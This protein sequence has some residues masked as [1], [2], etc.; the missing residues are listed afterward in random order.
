MSLKTYQFPK[1]MKH[2]FNLVCLALVLNN[3]QE[4]FSLFRQVETRNL[5]CWYISHFLLNVIR[6]NEETSATGALKDVKKPAKA[7]FL[8][9]FLVDARG[10]SMTGCRS[11]QLRIVIPPRAAEQPVRIT[12]RQ[13][14]SDAVLHP[15]PLNDGEGL[16][17]RMLQLSPGC[18]FLSP[19]L[20][21]LKY[22]SQ[23]TADREIVIYR[24]D[25]GLKRLSSHNKD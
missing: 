22:S 7:D 5:F 17:S 11:S 3:P 23:D 24:C 25:S 20:V 19:I 15:P 2:P 21:E 4:G 12:C 9:S 10:G 18:Q 8:V 13:M 16:A 14:R 6:N 1:F